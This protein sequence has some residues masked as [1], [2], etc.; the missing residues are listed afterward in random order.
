MAPL[1]REQAE[2][3]PTKITRDKTTNTYLVDFDRC[4]TGWP[5]LTLRA[6]RP[7]DKVRIEYFQRTD[8]RNPAGWDEYTCR[9]GEETWEPNFGRY[10]SF[11]VLKIT[12]YIAPAPPASRVP[13][14]STPESGVRSPESPSA[15]QPFSPS[16][17]S[18]DIRAIWSYCDADVAGRFHCSSDLL[19]SIYTLCERSARQNTQYAI[20][21]VDANREQSQWTADAWNIGN[22]LLYNH[23]NTTIIDKIIRDYAAQQL[24]NGNFPAC[25]PAQR[26]R[27]IP[28]WSMY[29]PM[30]LWQ[31]YLFSGDE[32]LLREMT[33]RLT[34]F[35]AWLK[36]S[37]S[38]ET[39]LI[40]PP[41]WRISEYAGGKLPNGGYNIAT[42]SQY[43][44]TLRIASRISAVLG[45]SAQADT[46]ARQS[47]EVRDAINARLFNPKGNYYLAKTD[48]SVEKFPLASAWPLRF[49]IVP[50]ETRAAVVASITAAPNPNL[51]GYGG[52]AFYSALLSNAAGAYAV[53]DLARYNK[54]LTDNHANWESFASG[55]VNHAWT[56]YP[57]YLFPKYILG[58]QPTSGGF[59]TFD[60]RPETNGLT[61]AEGTVPTVKGDITTRWEK[62]ADGRFTLTL[63]VPPNTR[64]SVYIPKPAANFTL[65]ESGKPLWPEPAKKIPGVIRVFSG[66]AFIKCEVAAGKYEFVTTTNP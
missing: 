52:D 53:R 7:G 43:Y 33:P 55:E 27:C 54:M 44:E 35:M 1:Q 29:W 2:L 41:G 57:A 26:S 59:A 39:H 25:A 62:T 31:Q 66:V 60:V 28:E 10:T 38:P 47:R 23:R 8:Q 22:V 14:P 17:L 40:N 46:Y 12:G 4:I 30:L 5:K 34:R 45:D 18:S 61:Y 6:N 20:I 42:N 16:A 21:A 13:R 24:P 19:N 63:T 32:H 3:L 9:G 37:Q 15:L 50:D 58:I 11:Q 51:G 65:T 49:N 56:A 48:S 64:A 36:N